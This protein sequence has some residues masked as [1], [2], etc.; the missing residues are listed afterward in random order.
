MVKSYEELSHGRYGLSQGRQGLSQGRQ[1][2]SQ[3][4][5]GLTQSVSQG[6]AC[7]K[8]LIISSNQ[9]DNSSRPPYLMVAEEGDHLPHRFGGLHLSSEPPGLLIR[10]ISGIILTP[11]L[12]VER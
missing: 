5:Q 9:H 2:L 3:G 8:M 12:E 7:S 4:R 1:G 11:V 6:K 10:Q